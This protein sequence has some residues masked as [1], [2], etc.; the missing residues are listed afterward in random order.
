MLS[1]NH[2]ALIA[3][4]ILKDFFEVFELCGV[5]ST[6][7]SVNNAIVIITYNF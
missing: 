5:F 7:I 3:Y 1:P 6:S 2:K 4:T